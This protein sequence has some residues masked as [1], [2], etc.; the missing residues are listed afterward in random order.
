VSSS[1]L[2]PTFLIIG[3]NKCGTS[4]LYRYLV[5]NPAVLP[6]AEKEPNFFGQHS[7]TYI[8]DHIN[9]YFALFPT[10]AGTGPVAVDWETSDEAGSGSHGRVVVDRRP[11]VRHITGEA[12]A[13]YFHDVG[14]RLLHQHLPA[15]KLIVLM[16][17]PVER[18]F[19][20]HRMYRRFADGGYDVGFRVGDFE[21]DVRAEMEA[22]RRGEPTHYIGP[23]AYVDLLSAWV[24]TYGRGQVKVLTAEDLGQPRR[25]AQLMAELEDYLGLPPHDYAEI[26]ARRFNHAPPAAIEPAL[27]AELAAFYAPHNQR[28]AE[29]LGRDLAWD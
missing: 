4:S 9:E 23:G 20:H 26:L 28:L 3:A 19:S 8:A 2:P 11:G 18:A 21:S 7:P 24:D 12:T 27:R 25:A 14:P 10:R 15:A 17:N 22:H 29:Y 1:Y 5:D 13:S 16:R 6:C